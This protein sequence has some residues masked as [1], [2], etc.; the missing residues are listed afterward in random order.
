MKTLILAGG[1]GT[2][3]WPLSRELMPKQFIKIFD[4]STLFQKTVERAL[5]FSKPEE[6]FIVANKEY[7]F[8]ILDDLADLSVEIP[9]E[10]IF[11]EPKAKSTL[12][13]IFW[14]LKA[15]SGKFAVLPSDHL[16]EVNEDYK[17]AFRSAEKLS[18]DYLVTFGI[19]PTRAHTGYGYIKPGNEAGD[20]F[21]VDEFKEKPDL[22]TAKRYVQ[23]GYYWNS[24]MFLFDSAI[25]VEEVKKLAPDV[26][27][28]FES[29]NIEEI[30]EKLPEISVDY[31][32]LEKSKKVAVVPL[33]TK[34]SDLGSF[35]SLY[36]VLSK[37]E[38][39]NVS[40]G[41]KPLALDSKKNLVI[42]QKLTA[43]IGVENL[44]VVD[45]E[46]ALLISKM[47]ESEKVRELHKVLSKKGDK[48][49]V[50]HRTAYRPW[51]S[52]TLL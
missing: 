47:G 41:E 5:L 6:I 30:Y 48:R 40:I 16:I 24:G 4:N 14:V 37:D 44:I 12:P 43:M 29:D 8:R 52:Y 18:D 11:L 35:D 19:K 25:F 33:A 3:L 7:K 46:D 38:H 36:E 2:R 49:I 21:I 26:F 1:K 20:G 39:G 23:S 22:E 31:G 15:N 10:N 13:A 42:S 32:I 45:T 9:M 34:W 17:R 50:V 27:K 28:A 51:G